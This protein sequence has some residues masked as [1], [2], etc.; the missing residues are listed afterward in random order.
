MTGPY[1]AS[2]R[3]GVFQVS[4]ESATR[5]G[6]DLAEWELGDRARPRVMA[7]ASGWCFLGGGSLPPA[8]P[9]NTASIRRTLYG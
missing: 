2:S 3:F 8:A 9:D 4:A 5:I 1:I 7:L 6:L